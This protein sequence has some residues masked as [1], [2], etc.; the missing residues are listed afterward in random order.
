[1]STDTHRASVPSSSTVDDNLVRSLSGRVSDRLTERVRS[2]EGSGRTFDREAQQVLGR[3]L[4]AEVLDRYSEERISQGLD[5]LTPEEED[6]IEQAVFDSIFGLGPLDRLLADKSVENIF[7]NGC[8]N[9]WVVRADGSKTRAA[10]IADSDRAMIELIRIA[11]ARMG[12]TE[13]RFD[14]A[15]PFLDLRLPDGSRLHAAMAVADRPVLSVRRHRHGQVSLRDLAD[16]GT[17]DRALVSLLAAAVRARL[18]IIIAG[19]TNAGK[20]TLLRALLAEV[21][22]LERLVVV[23][24][25]AELD[26]GMDIARHADIVEFE[27]RQANVEGMGEVTMA[28]LVREG[29][30]MAPDRVIVGEIRGDEVLPMLLA[31]SQGNDGS[32]CTVHADSSSGAFSRIAMYAA[33]TP[34]QFR[35]D[36]TNL[37]IANSIDL[38]IHLRRLPD[39]TRV[40]SSVREVT[41]AED[42]LVMSNEVF[43]PGADGRGRPAAPLREATLHRLRAVGF[44][45]ALL[46]NPEGWWSG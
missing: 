7:A 22:P 35:P 42:N 40:V 46:H 8:D 29:L 28:Q 2:G 32:L 10:P 11:A 24:D 37:L 39:G 16:L 21:E 36:V 41:G 17:L 18:N 6:E 9:V 30:R 15:S 45:D 38:V 19:G 26:L 12:R 14:S 4:L 44:D 5:P 20:T 25:S 31:M 27:A 34:E 33:M 1:M 43:E 23:E 13:R 3:Q